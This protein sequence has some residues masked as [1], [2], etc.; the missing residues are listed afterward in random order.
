MFRNQTSY[1]YRDKFIYAQDYDYYLNLL[2]NGEKLNNVF[3]PLIKYRINP[4]GITCKKLTKQK[5]FAEKARE[6]YF[7]RLIS[8]V[9]EYSL[10]EPNDILNIDVSKSKNKIV[11]ESEI[12]L[13]L[14]LNNFS[15]VK[16][17]SKIYFQNY[18]LLNKITFYY[19]ASFLGQKVN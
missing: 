15:K 1:F 18:G 17:L 11:L 2:T 9:D 16:K 3:K 8:G 7:Q 12:E 19:L 13:G 10:F 14:R 6:F 4:Q 5:L